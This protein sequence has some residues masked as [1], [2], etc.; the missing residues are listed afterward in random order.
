LGATLTVAGAVASG[1]SEGV[2]N[3]W[4]VLPVDWTRFGALTLAVPAGFGLLSLAG[5][6]AGMRAAV[7]ARASSRPVALG[8]FGAAL[9]LAASALWAMAALGWYG[10]LKMYATPI[11]GGMASVGGVADGDPPL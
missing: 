3:V 2:E 6:A 11:T 5:A 4:N 9:C 1:G 8:L 7:L 10:T